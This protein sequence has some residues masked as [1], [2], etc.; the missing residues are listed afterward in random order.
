MNYIYTKDER[1]TGKYVSFYHLEEI[2][3]DYSF[4]RMLEGTSENGLPIP[5]Y[6]IIKAVLGTRILFLR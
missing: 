2:L 4:W 1:I 3:K 6:R 5:L